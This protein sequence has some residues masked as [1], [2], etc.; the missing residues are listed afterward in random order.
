MEITC[1]EA[2]YLVSRYDAV[3]GEVIN[4]KSRIGL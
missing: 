3:T 4:L 1:G 2:P